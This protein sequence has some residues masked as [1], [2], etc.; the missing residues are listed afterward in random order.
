[1]ETS[2]TNPSITDTT[3]TT[4]PTS[5]STSVDITPLLDKMEYYNEISLV[6]TGF[7]FAILVAMAFHLVLNGGFRK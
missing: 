3:S 7:L 5:S 4:Q 2:T 1:M 6:Q